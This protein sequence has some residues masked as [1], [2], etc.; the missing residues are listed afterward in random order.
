MFPG[1]G[2]SETNRSGIAWVV[3]GGQSGGMAQ[4]LPDQFTTTRLPGSWEL[5]ALF[6]K[7][8]HRSPCRTGP[9]KRFEKISQRVL[10]LFIGIDHDSWRWIIGKAHR[11]AAR[12]LSP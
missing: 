3:Q 2:S 5:Q 6:V 7:G 12:P 4:R 10:Q 8:L 11:N 9:P 1:A